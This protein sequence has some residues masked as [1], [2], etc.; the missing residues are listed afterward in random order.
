MHVEY[1]AI[2]I[3]ARMRERAHVDLCLLDKECVLNKRNAIFRKS[4]KIFDG[5]AS[6]TL[7]IFEVLA[8]F[9]FSLFKLLTLLV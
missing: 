3:R 4:N 2:H 6:K 7:K 1:L 9:F 5:L 8:N